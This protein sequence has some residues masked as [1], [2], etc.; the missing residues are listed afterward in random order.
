[1]ISNLGK[2]SKVSPP[3]DYRK[4]DLPPSQL[5]VNVVRAKSRR[6]IGLDGQGSDSRNGQLNFTLF[7]KTLSTRLGL[8]GFGIGV[9]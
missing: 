4:V 1:M 9:K 3:R 8:S 5:G 2:L 7:G 6:L